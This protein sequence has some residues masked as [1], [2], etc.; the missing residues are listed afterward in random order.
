MKETPTI[1]YSHHGRLEDAEKMY[2]R[3]QA[4]YE[5]ALGPDHTSTLNTVHNLGS[6]YSDQGRLEDAEKMYDPVHWLD[7]RRHSEQGHSFTLSTVNS[8]GISLPAT[9]AI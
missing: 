7:T 3:A 2:D 4:G 5:K 6:L 9:W 8:L 1:L